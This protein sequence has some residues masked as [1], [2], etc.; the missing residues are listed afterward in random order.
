MGLKFRYKLTKRATTDSFFFPWNPGT[1]THNNPVLNGE[2]VIDM[3]Q[4]VEG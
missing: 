2:Y 3:R 1:S 4:I